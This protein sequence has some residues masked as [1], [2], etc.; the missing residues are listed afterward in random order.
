MI[1][2]V[3]RDEKSTAVCSAVLVGEYGLTDLSVGVPVTLG[4]SGI[5]KVQQWELDE[6]EERAF[7]RGADHLKDM[8]SMLF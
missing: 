6:E 5:E 3:L 7:L 1:R 2:S 4:R 8:L